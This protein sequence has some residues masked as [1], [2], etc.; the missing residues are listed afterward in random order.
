MMITTH[1]YILE[2]CEIHSIKLDEK[3]FY[4]IVAVVEAAGIANSYNDMLITYQ[5]G[6]NMIIDAISSIYTKEG[7]KTWYPLPPNSIHLEE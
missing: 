4:N 7:F 6:M 2:T 5:E 3:L 1:D